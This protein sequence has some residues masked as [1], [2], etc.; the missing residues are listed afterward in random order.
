M[1]EESVQKASEKA[2]K[3]SMQNDSALWQQFKSKQSQDELAAEIT[4]LKTN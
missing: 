2:L 4:K 3:T 1:N